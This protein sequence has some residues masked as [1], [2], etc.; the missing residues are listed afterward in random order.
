ML[1]LSPR[2]Q[3]CLAQLGR[4]GDGLQVPDSVNAT[5]LARECERDL[6]WLMQSGDQ[7]HESELTTRLSQLMRKA[8]PEKYGGF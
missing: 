2:H 1:N 6:T 5:Q 8:E 4:P 3:I 7:V